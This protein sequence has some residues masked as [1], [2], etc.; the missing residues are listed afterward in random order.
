MHVASQVLVFTGPAQL[1][2]LVRLASQMQICGQLGF[3]KMLSW[4]QC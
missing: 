3:R 1:L 4:Q 2:F